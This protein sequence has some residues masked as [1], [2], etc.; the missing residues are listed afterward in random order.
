ME[1]VAISADGET[2]FLL[3]CSPEVR[4][5][6][7]SYAPLHPRA[8]RHS[9]IAG[10]VLTNGDLDHC[11]GLLS[12]RESYPLR[13]YATPAVRDGLLEGNVIARTLQRFGEK[14]RKRPIGG[15]A[16]DPAASRSRVGKTVR[17]GSAV[18]RIAQLTA[19]P[20]NR[21]ATAAL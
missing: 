17:R 9:P 4:A 10:L 13:V 15:Q 11:L 21:R 3:N 14:S 7:E 12:L 5:Q 16:G 8:P 1:S 19:R 6:I 20:S 2:W 18:Q